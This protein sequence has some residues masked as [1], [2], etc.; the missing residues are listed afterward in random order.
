MLFRSK[1]GRYTQVLYSTLGAQ[2]MWA[3]SST[4]EEALLRDEVCERLGA[5]A[6]RTALAK[7]YPKGVKALI[8]EAKD[9]GE[10]N[11]V[12]KLAERVFAAVREAA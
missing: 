10:T 11:V 6:G 7:L 9:R 8:E 2:A 1:G 12:T 3:L 5:S 4:Q